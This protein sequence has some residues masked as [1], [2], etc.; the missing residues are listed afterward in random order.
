MARPIYSGGKLLML[1]Y[2]VYVLQSIVDSKFYIGFTADL[3]RRLEEHFRGDSPATAFRRPFRLVYCEY[4]ASKKDALRREGYFKTTPREES[5]E[6]HAARRTRIFRQH[7][8]ARFPLRV[9][10]RSTRAQGL[11]SLCSCRRNA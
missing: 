3:K 1:E 10:V 5:V 9:I 2:C 8:S 7:P 4:H 11:N 6:A